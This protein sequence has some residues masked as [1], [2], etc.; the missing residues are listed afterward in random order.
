MKIGIFT[1]SYLSYD[2][3]IQKFYVKGED[4]ISKQMLWHH[5][6]GVSTILLG[7]IGGYAQTGLIA[8]MLLVEMSTVFLNYRSMYNKDEIGQPVP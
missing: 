8:L 2:F 7:N 3:V 5:F 1:A 6:F 4:D